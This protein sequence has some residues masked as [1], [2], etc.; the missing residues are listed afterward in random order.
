MR[1]IVALFAVL[2][3][4]LML[5]ACASSEPDSD[6][7]QISETGGMCGGIAGF[8]CNTEG[9]FCQMEPGQCVDVADAAGICKPK[10]QMCTR[11]YRPVCGCDGETYPNACSAASAGV[12]V[13]Q[14]GI[15]EK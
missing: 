14:V 10:P 15:C 9:D 4:G 5:T 2:L 8:P 3:A 6:Q 13:A 12:S 7:P 11:D 1:A